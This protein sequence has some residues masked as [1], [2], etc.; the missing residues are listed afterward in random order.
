MAGLQRTPTAYQSGRTWLLMA[1][2]DDRYR[3]LPLPHSL[4]ATTMLCDDTTSPDR[5]ARVGINPFGAG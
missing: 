2:Y 3:A 1:I 4:H 5:T